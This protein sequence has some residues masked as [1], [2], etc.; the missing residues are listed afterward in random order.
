[1]TVGWLAACFK[2]LSENL[3][4]L[5]DLGATL[6]PGTQGNV[7][8]TARCF[9]PKRYGTRSSAIGTDPLGRMSA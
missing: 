4:G 1:M 6:Q 9:G 2:A 3:G 7:A 5:E 8:C